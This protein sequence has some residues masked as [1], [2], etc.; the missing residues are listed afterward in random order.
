MEQEEKSPRDKMK[1]VR[2]YYTEGVLKL[3]RFPL[4]PLCLPET[5]LVPYQITGRLTEAISETMSDNLERAQMIGIDPF[6]NEPF[7]IS[8]VTVGTS[9]FVRL[10]TSL[11]TVMTGNPAKP[12]LLDWH[13]HILLERKTQQTEE[14]IADV[15]PSEQDLHS[16]FAPLRGLLSIIA[17]GDM[18]ILVCRTEQAI[19]IKKTPFIR[20][21]RMFLTSL[22]IFL[23]Y[24]KCLPE[25]GEEIPTDA[26]ERNLQILV[27]LA[28]LIESIGFGL[29]LSDVEQQHIENGIKFTRIP[30]AQKL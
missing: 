7:E 6:S 27:K 12:V 3:E 23:I 14:T 15:V 30:G 25:I 17:S 5:V 1:I 4:S 20:V 8:S 2:R 9:H 16:Q 29:Y 26:R 11:R 18:Q 22:R 10:H 13:T 28:G 21:A 19:N 24:R